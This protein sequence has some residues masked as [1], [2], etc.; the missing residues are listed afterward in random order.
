MLAWLSCKELTVFKPMN[1]C[2]LLDSLRLPGHAM[3]S[4]RAHCIEGLE[5]VPHV[6][7]P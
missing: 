4:I 3:A 1:A 6:C 5:R 7:S 2:D